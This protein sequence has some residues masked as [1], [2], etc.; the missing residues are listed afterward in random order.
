MGRVSRGPDGLKKKVAHPRLSPHTPHRRRLGFGTW[1]W[2]GAGPPIRRSSF[3]PPEGISRRSDGGSEGV[4]EA[5]SSGGVL[6]SCR[7]ISRGGLPRRRSAGGGPGTEPDRPRIPPGG[8][9]P[10]LFWVGSRAR[11]VVI[12]THVIH[13]NQGSRGWVAFFSIDSDGEPLRSRRLP[14]SSRPL[15]LLLRLGWL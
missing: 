1:W 10:L 7:C 14:F 5:H 8:C 13:Y 12:D 4:A 2:G 9:A 11:F 15:A 3:D 6:W